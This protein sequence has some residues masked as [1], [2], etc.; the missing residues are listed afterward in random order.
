[1][2]HTEAGS[3]LTWHEIKRSKSRLQRIGLQQLLNLWQNAK[4]RQNDPWLWGDETEGLL[5]SFD[6]RHEHVEAWLHADQLLEQL[7]S[8]IDSSCAFSPEYTLCQLETIAGR[9]W[10]MESKGIMN[11]ED[12]MKLRKGLIQQHLGSATSFLTTTV[13]PILAYCSGQF[14]EDE[15]SK[16]LVDRL[17]SPQSRHQALFKNTCLRRDQDV[18]V[19]VPVYRD[20]KTLCYSRK[21]KCW[22]DLQGLEDSKD[23]SASK[24]RISLDPIVC[25]PHGCSLQ[26]T[27][28]LQDI[29]EARRLHDQ[30]IP[31]APIM[32]ALTAATTI[33]DGVLADSDVRWNLFGDCVDDRNADEVGDT[34]LQSQKSEQIRSR[35][36]SNNMFMSEDHRLLDRYNDMPLVIDDE[37]KQQLFDSGMDH[38][39]ADHFAHLFA[40]DPL[41]IFSRDAE[42][43]RHKSTAV[44][45]AIQSTTY[46]TVRFKAPPSPQSDIGWRV[47]FR[48]M[49][50]QMTD[51]ENAA[52]AVFMMLLSRTILHFDLNL[53]MPISTVDENMEKA[54]GPDSINHQRFNFRA[55]PLLGSRLHPTEVI[56][57]PE[58]PTATQD[59]GQSDPDP[60]SIAEC[61]GPNDSESSSTAGTLSSTTSFSSISSSTTSSTHPPVTSKRAFPNVEPVE[62]RSRKR[63]RTTN[64]IC[65]NSPEG[66]NAPEINDKEEFPPQTIAALINGDLSLSSPPLFPGFIPLIQRYLDE[67][68]TLDRPARAKVDE[69]LGLISARASGRAWTAAKWQREFVMGHGE[70]RGD[71]IVGGKVMYDL[72]NAVKTM[73]DSRDVGGKMFDF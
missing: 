36:S 13:C 11:V 47:E 8:N 69:Y 39:L 14:R 55:N 19:D 58:I 21:T 53:Y 40:R 7:S 30:L 35:W 45:E 20:Q 26:V 61:L 32:L 3:A 42:M 24:L 17:L 67:I 65:I 60:D 59:T 5:I 12:N 48:P 33:W 38:R 16:S 1:M 37:V 57:G 23:G 56:S 44:F 49:E 50:V 41:V 2:G 70:Y 73:Q 6:D 63:S 29:G 64:N 10:T 66:S 27:M 51:F 52:F 18:K 72:L 46:P 43:D 22:T 71:S 25:L 9:P 54:H 4:E 62:D 31:L 68:D 15:S 28:Q 34:L